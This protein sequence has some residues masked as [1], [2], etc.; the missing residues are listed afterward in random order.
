[1]ER[2]ERVRKWK[3][4]CWPIA[5]L[6]TLLLLLSMGAGLEVIK[7]AESGRLTAKDWLPVIVSGVAIV[8][9]VIVA[10]L[11]LILKFAEHCLN[12]RMRLKRSCSRE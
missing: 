11:L 12:R 3:E 5:L 10:I 2:L 6:S 9:G 7:S 8:V 1:M 4:V